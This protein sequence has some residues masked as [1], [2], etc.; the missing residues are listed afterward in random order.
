MLWQYSFNLIVSMLMYIS[1]RHPYYIIV[2]IHICQT[3]S[4]SGA[5]GYHSPIFFW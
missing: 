1:S 5:N 4:E 2:I 3:S